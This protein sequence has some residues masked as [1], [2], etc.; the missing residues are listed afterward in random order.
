MAP[1]S[2]LLE[3]QGKSVIHQAKRTAAPSSTTDV[4]HAEMQS[5]QL[6]KEAALGHGL[7]QQLA[8]E[9]SQTMQNAQAAVVREEVQAQLAMP[10][11]YEQNML[12]QAAELNVMAFLEADRAQA[13]KFKSERAKKDAHFVTDERHG[14]KP[15]EAVSSAGTASAA[16]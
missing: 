12:A 7:L 9:L 15:G 13:L 4:L 14:L 2:R 10:S 11:T 3:R 1:L 6:A 8:N 5:K 16:A